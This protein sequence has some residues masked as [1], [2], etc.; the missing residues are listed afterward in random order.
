[1]AKW[2]RDNTPADESI[3]VTDAGAARYFGEHPIVDLIGLNDHRYLHREH[4]REREVQGVRLIATFTSLLPRLR[5]DPAWQ[6]IHRNSTAHL[7]ICDCPQSEIV[8]YQR[9]G[10]APQ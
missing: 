10:P 4:G 8:A 6:V 2:L 3:A 7:T 1:M 9:R 5:D